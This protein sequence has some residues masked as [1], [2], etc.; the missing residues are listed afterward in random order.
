MGLAAGMLGAAQKKL[1]SGQKLTMRDR[2]M[3]AAVLLYSMDQMGSAYTK[4]MTQPGDYIKILFGPKY[5]VLFKEA[6][7]RLSVEAQAPTEAGKDARSRLAM[8]EYEFIVSNTRGG[9]ELQ[10][11]DPYIVSDTNRGHN[12]FYFQNLYSREFGNQV[13]KRM[14]DIQNFSS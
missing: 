9:S 1:A 8:L 12:M 2:R 4:G 5:Y 7:D 3:S 13:A 14:G 11:L 10:K 6:Y